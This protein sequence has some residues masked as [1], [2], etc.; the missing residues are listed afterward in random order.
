MK[1]AMSPKDKVLI[2]LVIITFNRECLKLHVDLR[3]LT[4]IIKMFPKQIMFESSNVS[5]NENR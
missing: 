4:E 2:R 1:A 5:E 3:L